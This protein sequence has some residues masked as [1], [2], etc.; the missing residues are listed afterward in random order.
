MSIQKHVAILLADGFEEIEAV[1]A[2]DVLR[3]AGLEVCVIAVAGGPVQ[4]SHGL[5]L[6]VDARLAECM[7]R[8]FDAVVLPGGM[9]GSQNLASS[10]EV[11][12]LLKRTYEAGGIVAAVC[13][14]P[15]ALHAAGLLAGK[16]VTSYPSVAGA[17]TGAIHTGRRVEVDG[18]I[19]TGQAAGSAIEFALAVVT[20]LGLPEKAKAAH[21][22]M[23]VGAPVK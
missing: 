20:A 6:H 17:L 1:A 19:V 5:A 8:T 16:H 21:D 22:A 7:H 9:P 11:L 10:H 15:I 12:A 13:A 18:R 4:G 3:R 14:A 2:I 23:L